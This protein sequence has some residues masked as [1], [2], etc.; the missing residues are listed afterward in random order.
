MK[1][2]KQREGFCVSFEEIVGGMSICGVG[3]YFTSLLIE[4]DV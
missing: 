1:L 4:R 2:W 3:R